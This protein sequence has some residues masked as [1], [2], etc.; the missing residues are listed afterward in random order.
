MTAEQYLSEVKER[1]YKATWGTWLNGYPNAGEITPMPDHVWSSEKDL[2]GKDLLPEDAEFIA[3]SRQDIPRFVAMLEVV[4]SA[5]CY[6]GRYEWLESDCPTCWIRAELDRLA[7]G[8]EG[9]GK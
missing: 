7:A 9:E 3:H 1:H 4:R 2:I 8:T 6:C 5:S